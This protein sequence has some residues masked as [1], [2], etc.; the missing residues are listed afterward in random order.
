MTELSLLLDGSRLS[1]PLGDDN[2]TQ[3]VAK[4][5][6]HFLIRR[7]PIIV[8][9][10][11]LCVGL[12]RFKKDTPTIVRHLHVIK[13]RPTFRADIDGGAQPHLLLLESFRSHVVPPREKVG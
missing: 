4:L 13:V 2:A 1:I 11:D 10:A 5:A 8:A 6:G 12:R 7:L 3:G 9:E